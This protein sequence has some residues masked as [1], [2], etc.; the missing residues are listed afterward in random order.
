MLLKTEKLCKTFG[1]LRAVNNVDFHID[2]G[3]V[4]A[5]IGPN[6]S[7]KTTFFNVV[8]GIMP[9]TAGSIVFKGED[10]TKLQAHDITRRGMARTFQ[11]IRLFPNLTARDNLIV[12]RYS[13]GRSGLWDGLFHSA[14]LK[15][16]ERRNE[17]MAQELLEFVGLTPYRNLMAKNLPYGAQRRLEIARAL[18]SEPDLILLDEP[19]AGMN[20][21]EVDELLKLIAR[22]KERGLTILLI[23]H[24]MRLVMNIA[25]RV[26][27]FDHGEK[28]AEGRP[29]EV[30]HDPKVVEAYIGP[31]VDSLVKHRRH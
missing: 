8:S 13:R 14:R 17:E 15:E 25:E 24:Q 4:V 29:H 31:E 16:E 23:E 2:T 26:V 7:G 6:G 19:A 21:R 18:A 20:P 28:I 9:A 27:V 10:V 11:N 3:E 5:I 22:L 12:G 1:G 30:R